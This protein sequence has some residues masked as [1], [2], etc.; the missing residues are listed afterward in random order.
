MPL[1]QADD[2]G[3]PPAWHY[4]KWTFDPLGNT[5]ANAKLTATLTE[6][7]TNNDLARLQ[8]LHRAGV[9]TANEH[10][11]K[12]TVN[13][14][15]PLHL[16]A[17]HSCC[18]EIWEWLL[19]IGADIH[20]VDGRIRTPLHIATHVGNVAMGAMVTGKRGRRGC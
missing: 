12:L 6:A 9:F 16:A 19:S 3:Y 20:A 1:V 10:L 18:E 4:R 2:D 11:R 7:M 15:T 14:S 17:Y 5:E 8:Q 13:R